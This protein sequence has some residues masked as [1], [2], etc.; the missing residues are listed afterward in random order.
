MLTAFYFYEKRVQVDLLDKRLWK[1][2]HAILPAFRMAPDTRHGGARQRPGGL[3]QSGAEPGYQRGERRRGPG[4]D[5]EGRKRPLPP[6]R[7]NGQGRG[8]SSESGQQGGPREEGAGGSYGPAMRRG[9]GDRNAFVPPGEDPEKTQFDERSLSDNRAL[10][11]MEKNGFYVEAWMQD[12]LVYR[13][14]GAPE[15]ESIASDHE[16]GALHDGVQ[17]R[18]NGNNRELV[19]PTPFGKVIVGVSADI[20]D[21]EMA[22]FRNQLILVGCAVVVLGFLGGAL[23][24]RRALAPIH[25][26]EGTAELISQGDY[27]QRIDLRKSANELSGLAKVLNDS[28]EKI[29]QSFTQQVRF[30]ADASHEMRTPLAVILAKSE[31]ALARERSPE[32]YQET[33]QSC[34]DSASHMQG[35]IESLLD[36]SKVDSGRFSIHRAPAR[37]DDL[38][39]HCTAL[40]EPLADRASLHVV[41]DLSPVECMVDASRMKQVFINLLSNA[42]KYN[43]EGGTIRLELGVDGE[44]WVLKV[45]DSGKGISQEH[46]QHLFDRFYRVEAARTGKEGST[47]LGLAITK[48]IVEAHGGAI[49]AESEVGS[50]SCFTL[51]VP[52]A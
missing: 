20:I 13:S 32:K 23:L 8:D 44:S 49:L 45:A 35:L 17:E 48:A 21:E 9:D 6:H 34:Y 22:S 27:S 26:M 38:V 52:L 16:L 1:P 14:E 36:L 10:K 37:L 43:R 18:W 24:T 29:E 28:F 19:Q 30:T 46:L 47:G 39:H 31:L 11:R 2:V 12:R 15:R 25:Q 40:L 7:R 5:G 51:R 42:I 33:I 3:S 50:G 4:A 41:S